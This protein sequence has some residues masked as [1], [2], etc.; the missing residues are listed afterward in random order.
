MWDIKNIFKTIG[1]G[2][3]IASVVLGPGSITVASKIGSAFSYE[4][5]W[6]IVAAAFCMGMYTIMAGRFGVSH[7]KS[8]LQT[9]A[10]IL[11]GFLQKSD[12]TE[13][14]EAFDGCLHAHDGIQYHLRYAI[15][16]NEMTDIDDLQGL[17]RSIK[18]WQSSMK[19]IG[20]DRIK[21]F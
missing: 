12:H 7:D 8:I 18:S 11:G 13:K 3:I 15:T 2:F 17:N 20:R 14:Y 21:T 16:H 10:E 19:N 4:L 1:P 6:I 5:L 9:I